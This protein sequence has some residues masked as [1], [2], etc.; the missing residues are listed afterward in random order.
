MILS[1]CA[2]IS[3][4]SQKPHI[5][6]LRAMY[7]SGDS[8]KW[9]RAHI[10]SSVL[11][12]F[13][14]DL[15]LE[16]ESNRAQILAFLEL[17]PLPQTPP[18]PAHNPFSEAK[19]ALGEKL[20]NDPR[21]SKSNQIACAS[22]HER[23]LGF[24]DGRRVSFG[25]NRAK[26]RRNAPSVVMSAF[27]GVKFWDGRA[28]DLESQSLFP[29]QDPL[30][31]AYSVDLLVVKLSKIKEY[32]TLFKNAFND[33]KITKERIAEALATYERSLMP[34]RNRFDRFISGSKNA[35]KDSEVWGLHLFRTKA[36]C[37]NCHNGVALS[38]QKFHN[39]GL[40]WYRNAKRRD[41]GRYEIT[42]NP[43][44]SGAFKTPS[45]RGVWKTAPYMH[46]GNFETLESVVHSYNGGLLHY[47]P[48]N[49]AESSDKAFPITDS[50]I[51]ELNL[52]NEE[53]EAI[54]AFLRVL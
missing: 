53:V 26:G 8:S 7:S 54:V 28:K 37:I 50:L 34:P 23:D 11:E 15:G 39:L 22:C 51:R 48:Q 47:V 5:A 16:L 27:G 10:D 6:T 41:L 32:S 43:A 4:Q 9:E 21:L 2:T 38:D 31:M 1:A 17:Q 13:A 42:N 46:N 35:L 3:L 14:K 45:L 20:F 12:A 33:S 18:Y 25:H 52:T 36:R 29:I 40:H 24:A 49:E 30:E 44:D 19:R